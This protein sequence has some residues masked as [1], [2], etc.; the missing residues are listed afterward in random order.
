MKISSREIKTRLK[1][2]EYQTTSKY[3]TFEKASTDYCRLSPSIGSHLKE[4]NQSMTYLKDRIP[5][6]S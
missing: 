4:V 6:R 1:T 2:L 5:H 3:M